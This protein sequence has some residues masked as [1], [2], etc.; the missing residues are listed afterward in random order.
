MLLSAQQLLISELEKRRKRNPA[1]SLR[2]FARDLG[3]SKTSLSDVINARRS[4]SPQNINILVESLGLEG[5][6]VDALR[7]DFLSSTGARDI[8]EGDELSLIEDW[9]YLA[10]L[11]LANIK[12]A[13]CAPEWISE[14][15]GISL[16][17]AK[18][19][20]DKLFEHDLIENRN[21][22]LI[23]KSKPLTTTSDIPSSSIVEHHHQSINKSLEALE[24][25]EVEFR[26]FTAVTYAFD[27]NKLKEA[28][29]CILDFHR[30]LGK[31]VETSEASEV[32]RLNVHLF[33][34]TKIS[35]KDSHEDSNS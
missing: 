8:I 19:S 1:Y 18:A 2:A 20:L 9:Q 3:I 28:K 33:P 25:V 27:L 32:Y 29:K 30:K 15:L 13:K 31:L 24:E 23:R 35:S 5:A 6:Q 22:T 11:N 34:L 10:I 16:D 26:D 12:E 4:F 14:R 7:S 21:G 17:L